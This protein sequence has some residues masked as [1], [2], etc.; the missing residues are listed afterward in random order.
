MY[1]RQTAN[2]RLAKEFIRNLRSGIERTY[3]KAV[4]S[5]F[6]YCIPSIWCSNNLTVAMMTQCHLYRQLTGDERFVEMENALLDWLFGC[7]P[8]G[9]SMIADLPAYGEFPDQPH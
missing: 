1:K 9:C 8:W 2:S 4:E 5:P 6:L 3:E 7:N